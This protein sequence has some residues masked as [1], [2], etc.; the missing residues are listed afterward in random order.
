MMAKGQSLQDPF[1]NALRKERVPVSIY[2]VNGIKL[3]GHIDSFDQFVVLLRN[4]V[5]QMVYKHAISTIVPARNVRLTTGELGRA[6]PRSGGRV[7]DR[8]RPRSRK[9]YR[10][11]IVRR[12]VN[13]RSCAGSVQ[14]ASPVQPILRS[15]GRSPNRRA[16]FRGVV[17]GSR[18]TPDP[19]YYV[20][21]GKAEE[22]KARAESGGPRSSSSI[23]RSRP[24][25]SVTSRKS[26]GRRDSDRS[27]LILDIFAQ[28]ARSHEGKLQV[29]LAQLKHLAT[30]LVRGWTRLRTPKRRHRP[31]R[32]R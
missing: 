11:S 19:R 2:L 4:N 1:L 6:N 10:C 9:D 28:R 14:A 23:T 24:A 25:R 15:F 16:L 5:S 17:T 12:A 31:A 26:T 27:G 18:P 7:I 8:S 20:G 32:P 29:E 13:V 21:S 3:Q 30:R 22:L